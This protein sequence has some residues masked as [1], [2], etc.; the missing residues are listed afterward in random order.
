MTRTSSRA[1]SRSAARKNDRAA[2]AARQPCFVLEVNQRPIL[3]FSARSLQ[4]AQARMQEAWFVEELK[5]MRSGGKP[6]LGEGDVRRIRLAIPAEVSAV[7][8]GRGLDEARGEDTKYGF[9]FL[10]PIDLPPN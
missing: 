5:S 7:E 10:V 9:A 8:I 2:E 1:E 6:L 4:S 3:A